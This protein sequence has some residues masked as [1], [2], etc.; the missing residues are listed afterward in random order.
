MKLSQLYQLA[1][2]SGVQV[3]YFPLPLNRS[4]SVMEPGGNCTVGMDTALPEDTPA[5]RV[6]L[7]H[8]LGHCL[9]GSFYNIYAPL[10]LRE[11]HEHRANAWAVRHL[12]PQEQLQNALSRGYTQIWELA[13]QFNVTEDFMRKALRLYGLLDA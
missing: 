10:D 11:K 4:V 5:Q 1:E 2:Q 6:C 3:C 9:T 7:A 13:E 12:V 8:E